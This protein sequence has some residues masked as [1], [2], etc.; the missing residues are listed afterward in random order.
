MRHSLPAEAAAARVPS[1]S[2]HRNGSLGRRPGV[3][4]VANGGAVSSLHGRIR[5]AADVA[6]LQNSGLGQQVAPAAHNSLASPMGQALASGNGDV[7]QA[8]GAAG[9]RRRGRRRKR[10]RDGSVRLQAHA[11]EIADG[12]EGTAFAGGGGGGGGGDGDAA[13]NPMA[14]LAGLQS[15]GQRSGS[16]GRNAQFRRRASESRHL[17][18]EFEREPF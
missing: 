17:S 2:F 8:M 15:S 5:G 14:A 3:Q 7:G 6:G 4:C 11:I 16:R 10:S 18:P 9:G 13:P 12:V 1:W